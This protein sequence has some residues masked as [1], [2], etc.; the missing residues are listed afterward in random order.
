MVRDAVVGSPAYEIDRVVADVDEA[1]SPVLFLDRGAG[2][3]ED[4]CD[5]D[6]AAPQHLQR[7]DRVTLDQDQLESRMRLVQGGGRLRHDRAQRRRVGGQADPPR[8]QTDLR[9]QLVGR[10]VDP[11]H[12]LGGPVGQQSPFRGQPDP[13]A[14]P[15]DELHAGGRF[16]ARQVMTHRRLR[17]VQLSGCLGHGPVTCHRGQNPEMDQVQHR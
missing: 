11:S 4:E 2:V 7:F 6:L 9:C 15:L 3:P 13:T 14:H 1:E 10:R 12:D 5:V 16:Q 8:P 17:V